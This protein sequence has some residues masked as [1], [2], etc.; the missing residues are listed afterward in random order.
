MTRNE[1]ISIYILKILSEHASKENPMYQKDVNKYLEEEYKIEV[2]RKTLGK[3]VSYLREHELVEGRRG[4]YKLNKFTDE[5]LRILIDSILYSP[6]IPGDVAKEIIE[7]LKELSFKSLDNKMLNIN[8]IES[9]NRNQNKNL[10]DVLDKVDQA[11]EN[12]QK[13]QVTICQYTI[14]GKLED[15]WSTEISPYYIVA[16]NSRYYI[17]CYAGRKDQSGCKNLES[18]RVDRI[19]KVEILKDQE[20]TPLA[21]VTRSMSGFDIGKYMR[22]HIY[23]FS[24]ESDY[25]TIKMREQHIGIFIDWYGLFDEYGSKF[26]V[27]KVEE[28]YIEITTK[29]NL[30]A[31]YYWAL[32]YGELVEVIKPIS[33][34]NKIIGGIESILSK[35]KEN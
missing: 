31:T 2:T 28:G 21:E 16:S 20:R 26:K 25:I 6:N 33:L 14:D 23:M 15:M 34:R 8:Y 32:Q 17:I 1:L 9:F 12:N 7:K 11:I 22:E 30:N 18:R 13:V 3:Y 4:I 35:Y 29:S 10:Y 27:K 19:S 24:G 5:E